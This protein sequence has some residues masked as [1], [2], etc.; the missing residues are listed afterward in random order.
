MP[1][2]LGS[3][4]DEPQLDA[5]REH[6][7]ARLLQG[8]GGAAHLRRGRRPDLLR[9]L[10]RDAVEAWH[11][12]DAACRGH[13]L[14]PAWRVER[15]SAFDRV[16]AADEDVHAP[17]HQVADPPPARSHRLALPACLGFFVPAV[18]LRP[19][20][21]VQLVRKVPRRRGEVVA[22]GRSISADHRRVAARPPDRPRVL[23]YHAPAAAGARRTR[24]RREV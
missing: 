4:P 8:P 13:V 7:L 17:P 22:A 1:S 21:A 18:R 12:Q 20:D 11:A 6:P 5:D 10:V 23:R 14:G 19:Q 2:V 16:H 24:A 3:G 15:R 9:R